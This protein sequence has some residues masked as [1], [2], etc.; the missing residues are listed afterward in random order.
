M[1][2]RVTVMHGG[3]FN[4]E[5]DD[6]GSVLVESSRVYVGCVMQAPAVVW[7][8]AAAKWGQHIWKACPA[9]S[10]CATLYTLEMAMKVV[11][12]GNIN[13]IVRGALGRA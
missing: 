1:W 5:E 4:H 11:L 7:F 10:M 12:K 9:L 6:V 3:G 8:V 2:M 13:M